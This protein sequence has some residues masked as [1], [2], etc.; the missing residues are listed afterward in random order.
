[1]Q[2]KY[3]CRGMIKWAPFAALTGFESHVEEKL[4]ERHTIEKPI[5]SDDQIIE[6]NNNLLII[7]EKKAKFVITFYED[8]IKKIISSECV[9]MYEDR[10]K[11]KGDILIKFCD[12]IE[13]HII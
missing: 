10:L 13:I 1:M 8:R 12:I 4:R 11:I 5:L 7:K 2:N 6:I 9:A 3:K